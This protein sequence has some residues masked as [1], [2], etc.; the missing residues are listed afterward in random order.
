[1]SDREKLLECG[2]S[3]ENVDDAIRICGDLARLMSMTSSQI[4][5]DIHRRHVLSLMEGGKT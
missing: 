3:G 2:V 5:G 1:M 4:V